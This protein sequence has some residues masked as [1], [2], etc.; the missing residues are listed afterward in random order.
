MMLAAA[1]AA[2]AG[3]SSTPKI[4]PV[5]WTVSITKKTT[6][7]IQVDVI[8]VT[9]TEWEYYKGLSL[10][11]YWG[12][13]ESPDSQIR[14]D[15]LKCGVTKLLEKDAWVL[16]AKTD[17][18]HPEYDVQSDLWSQWHNRRVVKLIL[19]AR[20]PEAGG[21]WKYPLSLD[22]DAW[23]TSNQAKPERHTIL[24]DVFDSKIYVETPKND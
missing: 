14:K 3:C 7:S 11:D 9:E 2:A 19:L 23:N 10:E 22:K 16:S 6:A 8:G 20:L 18:K 1:L 5:A 12:K 17:P 24:I 4:K 21:I 13:P 15:A